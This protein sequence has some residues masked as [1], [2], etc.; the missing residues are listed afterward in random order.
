MAYR[1]FPSAN[2]VGVASG[3]P[4]KVATETLLHEWLLYS[5]RSLRDRFLVNSG[6]FQVTQ[7]TGSNLNIKVAVGWAIIDGY[8]IHSSTQDTIGPITSGA[9]VVYIYLNVAT[10][11]GNLAQVSGTGITWN[12]SG[13][14]PTPYAIEIARIN[15]TGGTVTNANITDT[16]EVDPRTT[17]GSYIGD[18]A[19]GRVITVGFTPSQVYLTA[20]ANN[21]TGAAQ[22]AVAMSSLYQGSPQYGIGNLTGATASAIGSWVPGNSNAERPEIVT[23]GFKISSNGNI[24]AL[25][26]GAVGGAI[27]MHFQYL[28]IP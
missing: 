3:L 5:K 22:L 20:D 17:V 15:T 10:D 27:A 9:S 19:V 8:Y 18:Q 28:A 14:V 11:A 6:S 2:N 16:R 21:N 25:N 1:V 26:R 12:T 13:T 4:S 23:R 7:D 24:I